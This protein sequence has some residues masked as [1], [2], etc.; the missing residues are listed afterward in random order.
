MSA[1]NAVISRKAVRHNFERIKS[2]VKDSRIISVLKAN[3]YGHGVLEM[4]RILS[5]S[6]AFGVARLEEALQLRKAQFTTPI[7]LMEGF[8]QTVDIDVL[9]KHDIQTVVHSLEQIRQ[10]ETFAKSVNS[11]QEKLKVWLK[12]DTG[13]NRLGI[14]PSEFDEAV[15]RLKALNFVDGHLNF[16]THFSCAD[17]LKNNF[18]SEQMAQFYAL[19]DGQDGE[20]TLANSAGILAWPNSHADWVRPGLLLYGCSPMLNRTGAQD[21]F[22]A[23]MTLSTS[24]IA[25]KPLAKGENVGYGAHWQATQDTQ[26]A[27][28]AIG[29][30]DGYPRHAKAGT[31]VLINGKRYP[32]VGRVSMDMVTV[33]LG[34]DHKVKCG[35]PVIMW[36]PQL[37]VE[38]IAQWSDTICYE[39]ILQLTSRVDITFVE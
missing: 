2:I 20:L 4:A 37:P 12:V 18:T 3:A 23:A 21:D 30:G 27:V 25:I 13:M 9:L 11:S 6:D 39:L 22:V 32:I 17:D 29:Y 19:V 31:P 10:L 14:A 28:I 38:E 16:M 8:F 7:L 24:V 33:D 15:Q 36:G 26:L 1:V 35:D 34:L 5:D